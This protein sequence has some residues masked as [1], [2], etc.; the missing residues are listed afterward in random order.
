MHIE[1]IIPDFL[2]V[3][4]STKDFRMANLETYIN[5]HPDVFE[6]YFPIHCP[7][8]EERL[9]IAIANYPA[10]IED[11]RSASDQLPEIIEGIETEFINIFQL[12]LDL[13]YKLIVGTFGSNAFVTRDNKREIYLA[14]E[15]LSSEIEHLKVI[16]AHE[17]GHVAH[18]SFATN[19][20]MDWTKV[21]WMHGLTTL[22]LEGAATYLSKKVVPTLNESVYF[23]YD[24]DGDP[25]VTCY[26]ENKVEVKRRFLE[27]VLAGWDMTKEKEWFRLSGGSYFVRNRLGYLLGTDYVEHLVEKIGEE[28]ALTYWNGNDVKEDILAWLI[29]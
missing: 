22:Y 17:I 9:Q 6:Q 19:Q 25:W 2:A 18:F 20:G 21:D 4:D 27:D 15:K 3:Y 24:D 26:E 11:I 28:K 7:K 8:T 23:T 10:K 13:S 12:T 1:N 29:K 14:V 5:E 16:V